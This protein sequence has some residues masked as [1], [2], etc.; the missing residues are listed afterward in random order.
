MTLRARGEKD[1]SQVDASVMILQKT[2]KR[3][4]HP[5]FESLV[6]SFAVA[7]NFS[8]SIPAAINRL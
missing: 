2:N 1:T 5:K 8:L 3:K 6:T 7:N 4:L